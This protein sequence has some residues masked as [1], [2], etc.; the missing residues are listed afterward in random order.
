MTLVFPYTDDHKDY[1]ETEE[2]KIIENKQTLPKDL[3]HMKQYS[4][5]AC[6]TIA[7]F[8]VLGNVDDK[9]KKELFTEDSKILKF[10]QANKGLSADQ[11][12]KN[13]DDEPEIKEDHIEAVNEGSTSISSDSNSESLHFVAFIIKDN[14]LIEL[15]GLREFPINHGPTDSNTFLKDAT[16]IVQLYMDRDP[17]SYSFSMLCLAPNP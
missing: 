1:L 11:I 16:K 6:G 3:F 14:C 13:F 2:A 12:G 7:M 15:D 8:H 10:V 9:Y 17:E 5:N 4:H